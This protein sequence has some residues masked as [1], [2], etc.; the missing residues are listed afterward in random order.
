M[1][2]EHYLICDK[3]KEYID[4]HKRYAFDRILRKERPPIVNEPGFGDGGQYWDARGLWFIWKHRK[5]GG[6]LRM[7]YDTVDD[8]Y[9]MDEPALKEVYPHDEDI[10]LRVE[11][12]TETFSE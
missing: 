8:W 10:K 11:G 6:R 3:C 1:G 7:Q 12:K 2:I 4:L 9:E 5:H